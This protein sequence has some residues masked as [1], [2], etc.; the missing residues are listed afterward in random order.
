M[1]PRLAL[2][3]L[4]FLLPPG[5]FAQPLFVQ[6]PQ[7]P[8]STTSS[9]HATLHFQAEAA[10]SFEC[11]LDDAG[12]LP[13]T[14]PMTVFGLA[15]GEHRIRVRALAQDGRAGDAA[16]SRW[17]QTSIEGGNHPDLLRTTQQPAPVAPNGWRGILR[18]NC[19][20]SHA[21]Y[22]DPLVYPDRAWA[23]HLHGFYGLFDVDAGTDIAA[24]Y[25]VSLR[26][27]GRVSSCQ[28]NDLNRSAYW[29]PALLAPKYAADGR[30][31]LDRFGE[32]AWTRVEAVV[33]G[34]DE[35][36]EVFYYS[37]GIDALE[38]IQPLPPGLAMIAGDMRAT[39]ATPQ[40]AAVVR[41]HC[42][43]WQSNDATNP[44][45]SATIPECTA[46][47]RL[48]ADLFFP[49]C[50]NGRDLDSADHRSHIA[51]PQTDAQGRNPTCP[52]TH[53]V[54]V[55]R[56]SYHYA[57]PVKPD[58]ADPATRST[59]GWRL[60]SDGYEATPAAPGGASLHGDWINGWHPEAMQ[61]IVDTCIRQ[62]LDCHDGNLGNGWRLS[63]TA[64]G[65]GH[66]PEIIAQGMGPGHVGHFGGAPL[67][68]PLPPVRGLWFDRARDGHGI[69]LQTVAGSTMV[70]MYSYD[71][72]GRTVWLFGVGRAEGGI[73]SVPV[74]NFDYDPA[75]LPR[76][77]PTG[78][79]NDRI[80][81][82]FDA[83]DSHSACLDGV[84][85]TDALTLL[86]MEAQIGGERLQW[87][88]EPLPIG[89]H[90]RAQPDLTGS[91][92]A[93]EHDSGWGLSLQSHAHAGENIV[94]GILYYYDASGTGRW[95]FGSTRAPIGTPLATLA[96]H[97]YRG[98]CRTCA[99]LPYQTRAVGELQLR[100]DTADGDR[101]DLWID[102]GAGN[103]WLREDT[104]LQRLSDP[105]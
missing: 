31:E 78:A 74:A 16:E 58:T 95:A 13:C 21:A 96:L 45:F 79:G 84:D 3:M 87:C 91:W 29:V 34:D 90:Q 22:D 10:Q 41:W 100:W 82:R 47:D 12:F 8:P 73:L 37:A 80:D 93:G 53:P 68:D 85:R 38:T 70:L 88:L 26:A 43:T 14:S 55:V 7:V 98:Y 67:P 97:D 18:I 20:F 99:P 42:Q 27:D 75:R 63:G 33:G 86:A 19:D 48:R 36:H 6:F 72:D 5:A 71:G 40:S 17:T 92:Y 104:P 25:R 69:D 103:R 51:Y 77:R 1:H 59:R 28:G 66:A 2:L 76:Q 62:G 30:R 9:A 61:A 52:A 49:S 35:A 50:W 39:P 64:E 94:V 54:P 4:A 11:A 44:R 83:P 60:A 23:A 57:F 46:P 56:V 89:G 81:L 101:A 102:Y 24:M 15:P 65:S 105:P 32:P